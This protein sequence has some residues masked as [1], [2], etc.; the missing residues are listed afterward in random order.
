MGFRMANRRAFGTEIAKAKRYE[1]Y[2][3]IKTGFYRDGYWPYSALF[4]P[5]RVTAGK[6]GVPLYAVELHGADTL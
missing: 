6:W 2:P 5:R 1:S 3:L 4:H